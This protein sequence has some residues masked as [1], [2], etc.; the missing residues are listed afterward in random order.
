MKKYL[1]ANKILRFL[2]LCKIL[3]LIF[4]EVALMLD[5]SGIT[6]NVPAAWRSGGFHYTFC[7]VQ[8]FKF[9]LPFLRDYCRHYAKL[10]VS[11]CAFIYFLF[12]INL[13]DLINH[14]TNSL[15]ISF[16]LRI[17]TLLIMYSIFFP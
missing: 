16:S 9:A 17:S 2:Q 5:C 1:S 12:S 10:P 13:Y 14:S 6:H 8:T 4:F 7:G 11:G 15:S 3:N